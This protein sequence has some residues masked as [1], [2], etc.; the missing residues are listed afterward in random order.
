MV[1]VL[2]PLVSAV[3]VRRSEE[4]NNTLHIVATLAYTGGGTILHFIISFRHIGDSDWM[5]LD[6]TPTAIPAD[7]SQLVW[8]AQMTDDRFQQSGI[9]LQVTAVSSNNHNSNLV[10]QPE[11]IGE[12]VKH[13]HTII[14][15]IQK[16]D[17]VVNNTSHNY[18]M[19]MI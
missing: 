13:R 15:S 18:L 1:C 7:D 2:A 8:T 12:L 3:E 17:M 10:E 5:Q 14:H 6:Y 16:L 11:N 19:H 4:R 9:E